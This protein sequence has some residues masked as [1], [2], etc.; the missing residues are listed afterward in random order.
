MNEKIKKILA[1]IT[2]FILVVI[3]VPLYNIVVYA[4]ATKEFIYV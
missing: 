4:E 2:A 1:V 3:S